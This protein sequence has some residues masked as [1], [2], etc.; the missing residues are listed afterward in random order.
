[1]SADDNERTGLS[2]V[3]E[4][5]M[6]VE[7]VAEYLRIS[8]RSVYRLISRGDLMPVKIGGCTRVEQAELR[9][10]IAVQRQEPANEPPGEQS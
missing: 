7:E 8:E 4:P 3:L 9:R 1:M 6:G 5:L 10:F 2:P